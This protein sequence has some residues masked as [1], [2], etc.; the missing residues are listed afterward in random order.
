MS[1]GLCFVRTCKNFKNTKNTKTN[2][3]IDFFWIPD[4]LERAQKWIIM[5]GKDPN[6]LKRK[7]QGYSV[8][9]EHFCVSKILEKS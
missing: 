9:E 7:G 8:C 2:D 5:C 6:K 3:E 1:M 4:D